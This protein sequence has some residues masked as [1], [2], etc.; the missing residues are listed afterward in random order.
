MILQYSISDDYHDCSL[1]FCIDFDFRPGEHRCRAVPGLPEGLA[2][3]AQK[4]SAEPA[5]LV[6]HDKSN[7]LS[8]T[9]S[10]FTD[11]LEVECVEISIR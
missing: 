4:G 10:V 6:V 1:P 2:D 7:T 9:A 5:E 11:V 3:A 8:A